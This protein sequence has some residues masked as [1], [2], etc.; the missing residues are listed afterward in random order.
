VPKTNTLILIDNASN[1][2]RTLDLIALFDTE[3]MAN[4]RMKLIPVE[5]SLAKTISEELE[6]IFGALAASDTNTAIQF[7]PLE[8]I[9]SVLVVSSSPQIFE[10]VEEWVAK[11]DKSASVGGV[12]NFVY[13]VQYGFA[14]SLAQTLLQL[15]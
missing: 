14:A 11:L 4:Q 9:N 8:R 7:L 1:R 2:R 10:Q 12:Q 15:Y 5:N 3:E 13:K 6:R